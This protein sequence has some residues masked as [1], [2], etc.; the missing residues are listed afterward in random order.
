MVSVEDAIQPF[1]PMLN[2]GIS[3]DDI[4]TPIM[5]E[6]P[7]LDRDEVITSLQSHISL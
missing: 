1:I 7:S 2:R 6:N 5:A 4:L 3:L